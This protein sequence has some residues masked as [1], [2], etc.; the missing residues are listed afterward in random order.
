M[1]PSSPWGKKSQQNAIPSAVFPGFK[2]RGQTESVP[3]S[4]YEEIQEDELIALASIYGD[5]FRHTETAHSAWK[6]VEP[7]FEITVKSSDSEISVVLCVTLTAT[8]PKTAPLLTLK[9]A[10]GLLEGTR[11]KIQKVIESKPKELIAGEQAMIME[12]VNACLDVLEDAAQAKAAGLK[13]PSLEEE[14]A[15][16]EAAAAAAAEQEREQEERKKQREHLEEERMLGSL[17]QD[18]LKR[19]KAKAKETK[20]KSRP[21]PALSQQLSAENGQPQSKDDSLVFD[22]PIS[23]IDSNGNPFQFQVVASKVCIRQGPV[24]KCF[25]VRPVSSGAATPTLALKETD[26]GTGS[27][28]QNMFKKQLQI[29]E[30]DLKALKELRHQNILDLLDFKVSKAVEDEADSEAAWTVSILTEFAEKGSL[31]ELLDITGGLG[32]AKVRSWTIELLGALR[33]LHEHGIVHADMHTCNIL[34]V[35]GSS[36]EVRPKIA[37]ASFQTKL[38]NLNGQKQFKDTLSVA[39]SA[40]W[41]P[42]EI[43][44]TSQPQYTQKTDVWDFGVVFLQMA[45]GLSVV[46]KYSSPTSLASSLALSYSLNEFIGKLFKADPKKRPRAFELSSSEFLATDAELLDSEPSTTGSRLNSIGSMSPIAPRRPRHDSMNAYSGPFSRYREDFVEEG[47]LGKGGFGE[48][49]KARKK[50]DGQI[51]AIKK[52]TQSST[53]SLTEVLK[54][55]RLLSQLSHPSVVRYYNTW[56]EE[57]LDAAEAEEDMASTEVATT[58]ASMSEI[59]PGMGENVEFGVSTGGLDFM[60]SSGY[61]QVEFGYDDGSDAIEDSEDSD[62]ESTNPSEQH[63]NGGNR[64]VNDLALKR[65]RS[66]SRYQRPFKTILYISMEYCEKR[67]LRDLIKRGLHKEIDEIWRLMRQILEGLVHIHGLNVVHRDLKPENIFI[68]S[69]SNV[70]IGDFGLAT[71]GQYSIAEKSLSTPGHTMSG[72]MTRSI[73]TAFYV[74]PEV[75]S[76]VGG[77]SY[78]S[79]VDM[80]SLGIIFFEMCYRPLTPGM[81]R[82]HIGEGLRMKPPT[83]PKDFEFTEKAMQAEIIVSLLN[84][85]P[86]NRPSSSEL[87]QGGKLPVQMESETIRQTLAGISDSGSPYYH[88]MMSALF[89]MPNKQAKD[90]AWDM[91]SLNLGASDLLLQGIVKQKLITI[92]RNHG[93]VETPRALLF[94]R[95]RHY[96]ANAVQLLDPNGTLL[97]LPYDLTLPHAR[98]IAKHE[99]SV[100][101]SF[102]FGRIFRDNKTGGQPQSFGEVDFDIVSSDTLD[103]A[104][105]E[106]EVMKVLDEIV[107]SFPALSSTKMC[108][109]LNHSDL[110]GLIFDYCRIEPGIRDAVSDTLSKLNIQ[111]WSWQKIKTELRSP[112]IGMSVTS[113]DDL[114]N[115]DFRDTPSKAFQKLKIIFEGTDTFDKA[116]SAIAH[117]RDVIDY[118]KR[119]QVQ[120]KIYISPLGSLKEKFCK[121][122]V[123]F[124]C[125]HD[126]KMKDVFV[127]AAGGRYDSLIREHQHRIGTNHEQRHAVGFNL[128]WERL[129]RLPKSGAKGFL[130]K[131]DEE[132][133]GL[134]STKRCNILVASHDAAILRTSGVDIVQTL[135]AH[136]ISA[137]LA[138][139]SRSPEDLLSKYRD[140]QHSWI[141]IIKQDAVLKVKTMGRKDVADVDIPSTQLLPWIKAEI[142]ERDQ[143]EG[144]SHRTRLQRITSQSDTFTNADHPEQDVR[145]LIAGIKSKKSNRRNIIEQAQARAG[146]LVQSFLHG[147][148]AAIETTDQVLE[149][150][151]QT[152]LSDPDSWRKVTHAVP[153]AERRYIGEI[154]EL[155]SNLA[156]GN[157]DSTRNAF[158]YNFRTGTCIYYDLFL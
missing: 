30:T 73:G 148:I 22:Q 82:A 59:S 149:L 96:P 60:S 86:K 105:K 127:F 56:L 152:R 48:V 109:H 123:I 26:L 62:D 157:K 13:I 117:M 141:I 50:L 145:V 97:Q 77:G 68:D 32:V 110:L 71:S 122:G 39:K 75:S 24:S 70:K 136:D 121:G 137:E 129:A 104:L 53:M 95:S 49:V 102:A 156:Q 140:D 61:P 47:R 40:Y 34:L 142:R 54:E 4:Q 16:H 131:A 106:A 1:P 115:F 36:G 9:N 5:D 138:E 143:K 31:E 87:L 12:I 130:K 38:H 101:R 3:K 84:H 90:F 76:N 112:L 21:P 72:D 10:R 91:G 116:S 35:R 135:W 155:M 92:F 66:G 27:K 41:F 144:T 93:A 79:K 65:S 58:E 69:T 99:P 124:S 147:P 134:W 25:T 15:A 118:T 150:I 128:A 85:N 29:L 126:K 46:R 19:Q 43:A 17:V 55:V 74:A 23:L 108:F 103:L 6:K 151:R 146:T 133:Q 64:Y 28:D 120:S 52:I 81:E 111:S 100:E 14:R 125:L 139:D 44:N 37:D 11:F 7:S 98:S 154:H 153:T 57:V 18:E 94:P 113:I 42:P 33:F 67:T 8:Y 51:Y 114:Q 83:L 158:V 80:Y 119:F 132:P 63:Q 88:K 2:A 89:S 107:T 45:F 20:R 78:T